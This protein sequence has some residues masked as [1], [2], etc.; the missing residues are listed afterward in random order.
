PWDPL[1]LSASPQEEG[2]GAMV[3]AGRLWYNRSI[4]GIRGEG[5]VGMG[6]FFSHGTASAVLSDERNRHSLR[7]RP[8]L[9]CDGLFHRPGSQPRGPTPPR[10]PSPL[11]GP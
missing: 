10:P 5:L 11:A 7:L 1:L 4:A 9:L 3:Q 8:G 2:R 6:A